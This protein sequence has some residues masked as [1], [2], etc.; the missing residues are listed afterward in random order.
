MSLR[1][2]L[3]AVQTTSAPVNVIDLR[4]QPSTISRVPVEL[5]QKVHQALLDRSQICLFAVIKDWVRYP[6]AHMRL[7]TSVTGVEVRRSLARQ[8]RAQVGTGP[9]LCCRTTPILLLTL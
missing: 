9:N 3:A 8:Y 7:A 6:P 2:R 4:T 1:D 5:K